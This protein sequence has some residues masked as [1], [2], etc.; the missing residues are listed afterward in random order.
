[1]EL[2]S[3]MAERASESDRHVP[4]SYSDSWDSILQKCAVS[5]TVD[6]TVARSPR[7]QKNKENVENIARK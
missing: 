2:V 5:P 1:M 3:S 4:G 6:P 7:E